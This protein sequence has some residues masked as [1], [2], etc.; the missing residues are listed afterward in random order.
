[1][2]YSAS[3]QV[4]RTSANKNGSPVSPLGDVV[5]PSGFDF[6][7]DAFAVSSY[8]DAIQAPPAMYYGSVLAHGIVDNVL[9]SLPPPLLTR[10][11]LRRTNSVYVADFLS[12]TN[13]LYALE[14]AGD[15]KGW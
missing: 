9:L 14:G 10:L 3:D 2:N 1:M 12:S 11:S 8:S 5:L 15:L 6:R 4:L 7:V 13:W